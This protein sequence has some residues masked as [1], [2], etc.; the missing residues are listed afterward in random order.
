VAKL[1]LDFADLEQARRFPAHGWAINSQ[2]VKILWCPLQRLISHTLLTKSTSGSLPGGIY[3]DALPFS[4]TL[5]KLATTLR[6]LHRAE[7]VSCEHP[8]SIRNPEVLTA[9]HRAMEIVPLYV[10]LAFIYLR[11]LPDLL[12]VACR[13]LLFEHW[14]S[15]STKFK[16]WISNADRLASC[17]PSCNFDVLRET[18]IDHSAWFNELRDVSPV[19]GKKGIRDALEHRGV[20]LIVGKQQAGDGRPYFTVMTDSR[21]SDV[22][23]HKD[24]L[25]LIPD[26]VAGLCLLMAGIHSAIGFSSQYEWGDSLSLI[27]TDDDIVGYWPQIPATASATSTNTQ[28]SPSS[29]S[30]VVIADKANVIALPPLIYGASLLLGIVIHLMFPISFLPGSVGGW[31]GGLLI[32]LSILI[33]GSAFRALGRAK[34]PFDVHQPTVAIVTDGAFRYSRNPMY[35]SLTLLYLGLTS[36]INSLWMLLLVVPLIVVMQRGVVEREEQYLEGKFGEEY[37]RYKMRVRRWI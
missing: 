11:R 1:E 15:V 34:T 29:S 25:P 4:E 14:Q 27:G 37:L 35:L 26:S 22:E 9:D 13:P 30:T 3:L 32:L 21:A 7:R 12:V 18:L 33:V 31:L 19:T 8:L 36:L 20:R 10:E 17:K 23:I 28:I 24:I 5:Q 2:G 6:E 16:D